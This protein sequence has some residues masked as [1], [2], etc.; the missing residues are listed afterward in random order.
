MSREA[1]VTADV[2]HQRRIFQPFA[3]AIRKAMDR[4]RLIEQ[5]KGQPYDLIRVIGVIA[6]ALREFERAPAPHVWN[7]VDLRDLPPVAPDVVEHQPF[8]QREV[9]QRQ[10]FGSETAKNR[11]EQYRARDD[12][13]STPRV[14]PGNRQPVLKVELGNVFSDPADLLGGDMK[15]A[16]LRRRPASRGGCGH[17]ANAQD[18]ARSPNHT[19]ET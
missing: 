3:F 16:Q 8:A 18:G 1:D 15:I 14:E 7:A 2:V 10:F 6:A 19:I 17:S 9:T 11:V 4:T 5:G 13:V 12:E